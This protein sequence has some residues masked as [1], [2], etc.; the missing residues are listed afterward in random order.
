MSIVGRGLLGSPEN[1]RFLGDIAP[2]GIA[3]WYHVVFYR[4]LCGKGQA[5][6]LQNVLNVLRIYRN[7]VNFNCRLFGQSRTVSPYK[8]ALIVSCI[9]RC[10]VT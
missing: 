3:Y 10:S 4:Y 1:Q 7:N 8:D 5:L 9:Y 6:S 2:A